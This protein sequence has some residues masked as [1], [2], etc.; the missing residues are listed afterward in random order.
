MK[1]VHYFFVACKLIAPSLQRIAT[2]PSH[3][4]LH[5]V[6]FIIISINVTLL[7]DWLIIDFGGANEGIQRHRR[8]I[9]G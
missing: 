9:G 3:D 8:N 2:H 4:L 7:I 1:N 5:E 6:T